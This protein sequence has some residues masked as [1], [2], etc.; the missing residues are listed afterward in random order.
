MYRL[1]IMPL[2]FPLLSSPLSPNPLAN[3]ISFSQADYDRLIQGRSF[4]ALAQTTA[5]VSSQCPGSTLLASSTSIWII[6]SC[7]FNHMSESDSLL[8]QVS[9]LPKPKSVFIADGRSCY[10]RRK[11][12]ASPTPQL[13]LQDVLYVL[14]FL[15]NLISISALT[16]ALLCSM[17]F[18]P[19]H[20]IF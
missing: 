17:T 9:K 4:A 7:A 19:H 2:S 18:F 6:D 3:M 11:G 10:V 5:C 12:S 1:H 20:C 8:S 14:Y 15:V 13:P 16:E